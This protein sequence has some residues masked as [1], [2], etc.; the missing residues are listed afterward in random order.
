[1]TLLLLAEVEISLPIGLAISVA[2]VIAAIGGTWYV[3]RYKLDSALKKI[4]ANDEADG[5]REKSVAGELKAL[6]EQMQDSI[7]AAREGSRDLEKTMVRRLDNLKDSVGAVDK[8]V[9]VMET[10]LS[11]V[12]DEQRGLKKKVTM[13]GRWSKSK[14]SDDTL[15]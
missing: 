14:D 10:E 11:H 13:F 2:T 1:M 6:R 3:T 15:S 12:K 5:Q 9:S 8:K 4:E 7:D